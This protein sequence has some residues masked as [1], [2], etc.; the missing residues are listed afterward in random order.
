MLVIRLCFFAEPFPPFGRMGQTQ[1]PAVSPRKKESQSVDHFAFA[2]AA[3][4]LSSGSSQQ[5]RNGLVPVG[6]SGLPEIGLDAGEVFHGGAGGGGGSFE[7][8]CPQLPDF[9]TS[10]IGGG[11]GRSDVCLVA[12]VSSGNLGRH[13]PGT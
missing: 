10:G 2:A 4:A 9:S 5:A 8:I 13:S 11:G 3:V 7:S 6:D 1:I 12:V